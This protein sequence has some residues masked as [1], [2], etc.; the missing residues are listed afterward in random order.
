MAFPYLPPP[1]FTPQPGRH[2]TFVLCC[3]PP[4]ETYTYTPS[5]CPPAPS[6]FFFS[7]LLNKIISH[8][9]VHLSFFEWE[10][11]YQTEKVVILYSPI[12]RPE[13]VNIPCVLIP[14]LRLFPFPFGFYQIYRFLL[15]INFHFIRC[16]SSS[17]YTAM[18]LMYRNDNGCTQKEYMVTQS[19]DRKRKV[20][21]DF[22]DTFTRRRIMIVS[23]FIFVCEPPR[24][25]AILFAITCQFASV[26]RLAKDI[27]MTFTIVNSLV[28]F[29]FK[30]CNCKQASV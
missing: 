8:L 3:K 26:R 17:S 4:T 11:L 27:I 13:S 9:A 15:R 7:S 30:S 25:D 6:S 12:V 1:F 29:S 14:I 21:T 28:L 18:L 19:V 23:F 16:S 10:N 5:E 22:S 24:P 20:W 2:S